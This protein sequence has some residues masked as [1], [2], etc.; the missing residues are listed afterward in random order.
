MALFPRNADPKQVIA[1]LGTAGLYLQPSGITLTGGNI[2]TWADSGGGAHDFTQGTPASRPAGSSFSTWQSGT[3][4]GTALDLESAAAPSTM[5]SSTTYTA[6]LVANITSISTTDAALPYNNQALLASSE[7]TRT[8]AFFALALR[9]SVGPTAPYFLQVYHFHSGVQFV[10][11]QIPLG[12]SLIEVTYSG[13]T[14]S[15]RVNGGAAV[16]GALGSID[17]VSG[18]MVLGNNFNLSHAFAGQIGAVLTDTTVLS[19]EKRA[20]ARKVLGR[21]Y[22]ATW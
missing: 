14:V 3:W 17:S 21:A 7:V 15:I 5:I 22:G 4:S 18:T 11:A 13:G 9:A 8:S 10:E 6:I 16:T 12:V 20:W 19:A 2:S 1:Q